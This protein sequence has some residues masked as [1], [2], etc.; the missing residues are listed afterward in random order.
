LALAEHP[1]ARTKPALH[2]LLLHERQTTTRDDE[3]GM[4][5]AVEVG[6]FLI[7]LKE[8]FI[9]KVFIVRGFG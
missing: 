1:R 2:E 4:D 6:S 3:P 5:Q 8:S 9:L 7:D